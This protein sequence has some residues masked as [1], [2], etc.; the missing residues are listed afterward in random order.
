MTQFMIRNRVTSG[1]TLSD[2]GYG[3]VWL[4][5]ASGFLVIIE[6]APFDLLILAIGFLALLMGLRLPG[7]LMPMLVVCTV[8]ILCGM[9]ALTQSRYLDGSARHLVITIYL[10]ATTIIVAAF[11]HHNPRLS[12]RAILG[13]HLVAALIS[14]SL[15]IIGYFDLVPGTYE[16]FTEFSRAKGAFKDPN[17]F[18]PFLI[19]GAIYALYQTLTRPL[20]QGLPWLAGLAIISLGVLLSFSRGAWGHFIASLALC[21]TLILMTS[22]DRAL[23]LRIIVMCIIAMAVLGVA[24]LALLNIPAVAEMVSMRAGLTQSYDTGGTGRFDG[25]AL[26]IRWVLDAPL[27]YGQEDFGRFWGEEPHNVYIYMFLQTGW[28][29]GCLYAAMVIGTIVAIV[30]IVF[31]AT[32]WRS[33]AIVL[34]ATFIPLALEGLI[35]DTDHWRHFWM[36]LGMIWGLAAWQ[37]DWNASFRRQLIV[38][39][40]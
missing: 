34:A 1:L 32:P 4:A 40:T 21:V 13:G 29:G 12:L 31:S 17:V 18:G 24:V 6:P 9:G 28:L 37:H 14:A 30:R 23:N 35:V 19:V 26:A 7:S 38:Q 25:Q 5:F 15:G 8:I 33:Y 2:L 20:L 3:L 11:V 10:M 27:G 36:L 16:L 22:R 39:R